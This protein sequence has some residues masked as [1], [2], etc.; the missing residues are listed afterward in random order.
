MTGARNKLWTCPF[1]LAHPR[2]RRPRLGRSAEVLDLGCEGHP[3]WTNMVRT[4][5]RPR[6]EEERAPP[7]ERPDRRLQGGGYTQPAGTRLR[8]QP[9]GLMMQASDHGH[10]DDSALVGVLHRS[11][12]RGVLL[13]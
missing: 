9:C 12:L 11:W 5:F 7:G 6:G 4:V 13:Q 1:H 10:L 8:S 2:A 3:A